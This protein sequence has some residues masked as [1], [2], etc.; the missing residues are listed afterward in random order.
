MSNNA[1]KDKGRIQIPA[2]IPKRIQLPS[3]KK[4]RIKSPTAPSY[5]YT[6]GSTIN[7]SLV[8]VFTSNATSTFE[9]FQFQSKQQKEDLLGPYNFRTA[10]PWEL[11]EE[12]EERS[13]D[14]EFTYQQLITENP[15]VETL[16]LQA[17][18]NLN[19]ENLKIETPNHQRQNNLNSELINQQNLP[20]VIVID[21]P[22]INPVAEPIQ[23][24]FQ[25]PPQQPVEQQPL[26]Q[27]PQQ[28]NLDPMAYTPIAK[29]DN[30]TSEKDDM[31]V[32]LND[33]EKAII[34]NGWNDT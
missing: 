27:P 9:R 33:V 21:Q 14:Q 2:A 7:I 29:L 28:S 25:L 20:L 34:A 22:P 3:W 6:S 31:Q 8:D 17:Q 19:L 23:Q 10:T 5:H 24:P 16:N 15:E 11:L 13:K 18:Q 32:W 30:F 12:E 1:N 26:Q 4:H